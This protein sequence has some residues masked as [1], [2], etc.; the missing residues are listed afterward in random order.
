MWRLPPPSPMHR[1]LHDNRGLIVTGTQARCGKTVLCAGLIGVLNE[2]GFRLQAIKPLS[3]ESG[4]FFRQTGEQDYFDRLYRELPASRL[5]GIQPMERWTVPSP[6]GFGQNEW[7]RLLD[8]GRRR[9]DPYILETPG[10]ISTPIRTIEEVMDTIDLARTLSLPM[11]LTTRKHPDM[12][13]V[14]PTALAYAALRDA[15]LMG[16]IAVETE[17]LSVSDIDTWPQNVEYILRQFGVPYLGEVAY[18]PSISVETL[19][20]GN[21][22]RL[23]EAGLDLL[24]IQQA[25][26]VS[27]PL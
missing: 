13:S 22:Y 3:Y 10:S 7:R 8:I 25:L 19:R 20:Q 5:P 16:W 11:L 15:P 18:S 2:L 14:L 9:I 17:P 1:G 23:T 21:L 27:I 4:A 26:D 24:P 6:F 12:L